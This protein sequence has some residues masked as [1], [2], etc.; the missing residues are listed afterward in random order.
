MDAMNTK[1]QNHRLADFV[2]NRINSSIPYPAN[3]CKTGG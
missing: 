3:Q 2:E 1:D